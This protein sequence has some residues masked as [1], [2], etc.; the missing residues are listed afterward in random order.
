MSS[1]LPTCYVVFSW[2]L[3]KAR[4]RTAITPWNQE[5]SHQVTGR[6]S[7]SW[8]LAMMS[9]ADLKTL[10]KLAEVVQMIKNNN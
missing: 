9:I 2:M 3:N 7:D 10:L 5:N 6:Y 8:N 4:L 1:L